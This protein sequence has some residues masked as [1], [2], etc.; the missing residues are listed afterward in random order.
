MLKAFDKGF[1]RVVDKAGFSM[2][3][4]TSFCQS[5]LKGFQKAFIGFHSQSSIEF[6]QGIIGF[7]RGFERSL[8][9]LHVR[10]PNLS[11]SSKCRII[12]YWGSA[13]SD[14]SVLFAGDRDGIRTCHKGSRFV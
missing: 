1:A 13:N 2:R 3:A 5:V 10:N 9:G 6:S 8:E 7:R 12:G 4:F 11:P 14:G